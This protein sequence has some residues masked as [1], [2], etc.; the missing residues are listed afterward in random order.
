M[1]VLIVAVFLVAVLVAVL[2][3]TGGSGRGALVGHIPTVELGVA[4]GRVRRSHLLGGEAGRMAVLGFEGLANRRR[5]GRDAVP[6]SSAALARAS[7]LVVGALRSGV[8]TCAGAAL[9][10][11]G[12]TGAARSGS[13]GGARGSAASVTQHAG[14]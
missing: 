5:G 9:L 7:G 12:G 11:V 14:L 6:E 1:T 4:L 3:P 10:L 2:V 13:H 8:S